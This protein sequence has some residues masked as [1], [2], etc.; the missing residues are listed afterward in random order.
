MLAT[1]CRVLYVDLDKQRIRITHR[2]DLREKELGGAGVAAKLLMENVRA[3][4]PPL[5]PAQ[6]MVLAHGVGTFVY[7][8]LTQTVAMFRSPIHGGLAESRAGGRLA[9]CLFM[10]G[11]DAVVITGR[12]S[13]PLYLTLQQ[14]DV[15]FKDARILW[16]ASQ[17]DAGQIIRE[18]EPQSGKRSI[19][20]IG[21]AGEKKVPLASVRVDTYQSF[22]QGFGALMGSKR[23]KAITV[24]AGDQ[25]KAIQNLPVYF[26]VFRG[27]H[28]TCMDRRSA[29]MRED[30]LA[31][32]HLV[33]RLSCTGCPV[34]CIRI[35]QFRRTFD[36]GR[37]YE[38][39]QVAYDKRRLWAMGDLLGMGADAALPLLEAADHAG[40]DAVAAGI[41]L[42]WATCALAQGRLAAADTLEPLAFGEGYERAI[43]HLAH[44][45]NTFYALLGRGAHEAARV[46][47]DEGL[48]CTSSGLAIHLPSDYRGLGEAVFGLP[49]QENYG[50]AEG[51]CAASLAGCLSL[52]SEMPSVYERRTVVNALNAIN[53]P[54]N[55]EDLALL[56]ER[57]TSQKLALQQ[58]LGQ[59]P[60][61]LPEN[62]WQ[63]P[64]AKALDEK[65]WLEEQ[66][67]LSQKL[68][69]LREISA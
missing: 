52:C 57:V 37:Q 61:E 7:P 56:A 34:G 47:G 14:D 29:A 25:P 48:L 6:P 43:E 64:L 44:R 17:D 66:R 67:K 27:I 23:L 46:Y 20:R 41:A 55:G 4:L 18:R 32:Q 58:K 51:V 2:D 31:E 21:P 8:M 28:R 68:R 30:P 10:A 13:K 36:E 22:D 38:T 60:G 42:R 39:V 59:R 40:V 63:N 9:M 65:T 45:R 16:G 1:G 26:D 54:V 12:S 15:S 19:L 3:E 35:G 33:R 49:I 50:L 5:D 11:Y 62:F 53:I 24:L 69:T